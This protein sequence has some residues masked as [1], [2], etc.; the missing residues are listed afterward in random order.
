LGGRYGPVQASGLSATHE[1]FREARSSKPTLVFVQQGIS[2]ESQQ[3]ALIAEARDWAGGGIAPSFR[4]ADV[5]Q[6]AIIR[7]L[8]DLELSRAAGTADPA[9][10]IERA[11]GLIPPSN[12]VSDTSLAVAIACGPRQAV[13][14]PTELEDRQLALDL[15][16]AALFGDAALLDAA[17]GT[18]THVR[19][20]TLF[21]EQVRGR[22]GISAEGSILV[23]RP[24]HRNHGWDAGLSAVIEEDVTEDLVLA[25]RF[26]DQVLERI[27]PTSRLTH[28]APAVALLRRA[29]SAWRTRAEHAANRNSMTVNVSGRDDAFAELTPPARPRPALRHQATELAQDLTALLRR[30]STER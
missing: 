2:A 1:E 22:I 24:A 27:D 21:I 12:S 19:G 6:A 16:Q 29:F 13:L 8:H 28:I 30:S 10:M 20:A 26:A 9:E 4:D 7:G 3:A 23:V 5:L 14:R 11:R 15:M 18:S 25:L 17:D